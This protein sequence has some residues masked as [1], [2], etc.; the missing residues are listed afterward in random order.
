VALGIP[1]ARRDVLSQNAQGDDDLF[2]KQAIIART[3]VDPDP[4]KTDE[5]FRGMI[6]TT[7]S[8]AALVTEAVTRADQEM[9]H[10]L[11]L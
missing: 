6:E 4:A 1:S 8:G 7:T 5:I 10:I 3:W 9:A 2:N 11:G